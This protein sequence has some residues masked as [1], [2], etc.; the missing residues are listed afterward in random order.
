MFNTTNPS[1]LLAHDVVRV[2]RL[3]NYSGPIPRW[4]TYGV[5][6]FVSLCCPERHNQHYVSEKGSGKHL[7]DGRYVCQK[8]ENTLADQVKAAKAG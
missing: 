6:E 8:G 7:K 2:G 3:C 4:K 5:L 1:P